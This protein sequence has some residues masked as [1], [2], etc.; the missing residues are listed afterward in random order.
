MNNSLLINYQQLLCQV[1]CT[2]RIEFIIAPSG[3]DFSM[4]WWI[5]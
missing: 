2:A 1:L 3:V 4:V 5:V